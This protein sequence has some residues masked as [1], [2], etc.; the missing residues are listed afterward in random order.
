MMPAQQLTALLVNEL[1]QRGS[2]QRPEL[3]DALVRP[4]I[5]DF[6][7]FGPIVAWPETLAQRAFQS[8][9]SPKILAKEG[10]KSK[11]IERCHWL[12]CKSSR[13]IMQLTSHFGRLIS[14]CADM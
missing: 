9:A 4:V 12:S 8:P 7:A 14:L 11:W 13:G 2:G 5:A 6:P 1:I 3:H 10:A